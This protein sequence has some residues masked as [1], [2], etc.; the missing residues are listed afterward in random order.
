MMY[1]DS[2]MKV[3]D[4]STMMY[5]DSTLKVID[6]SAMMYN[7]STMKVMD[8]STMKSHYRRLLEKESGREGGQL[9]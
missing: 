1:N 8:D 3:I 4:E 7:D 6:A 2:T 5:N 9:S